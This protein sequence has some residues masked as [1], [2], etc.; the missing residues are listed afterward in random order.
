MAETNF[1]AKIDSLE[2][3]KKRLTTRCGD[4]R[5]ATKELEVKKAELVKVLKKCI[6]WMQATNYIAKNFNLDFGG[7]ELKQY[8]ATVTVI[9][10]AEAAIA[11]TD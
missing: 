10:Q 11:K 8:E 3:E 1:Q 9:N 7:K 6:S 4:L 5:D 2:A